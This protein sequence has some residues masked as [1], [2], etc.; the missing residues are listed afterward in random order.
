MFNEALSRPNPPIEAG[1]KGFALM[2][3]VYGLT[4][5]KGTEAVKALWS[6]FLSIPNGNGA[7]SVWDAGNTKTNALVWVAT[8]LQ[9]M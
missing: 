1:W 6:Q 9:N 5:K 8:C 3:R 4:V 2:A 7:G